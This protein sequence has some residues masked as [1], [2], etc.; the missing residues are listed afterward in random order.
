MVPDK[1]LNEHRLLPTHLR[2]PNHSIYYVRNDKNIHDS[3]A[4]VLYGVDFVNRSVN[5]GPTIIL[6][7]GEHLRKENVQNPI[8]LRITTCMHMTKR[9]KHVHLHTYLYI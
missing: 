7:T 6:R 1:E 9:H 2:H 4:Y 3:E 5:S 8:S